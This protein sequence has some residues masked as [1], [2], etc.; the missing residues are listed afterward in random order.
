MKKILGPSMLALLWFA[1]MP[2][3]VGSVAIDDDTV[4]GDDDDT[5]ADDDDAAPTDLDGDGFT[6]ADGDCNDED[7]TIHPDA[8]EEA[9]DGIDQDCDGA[10]WAD[11]DGDGHDWDGVGGDDCD[12]E[13]PTTYTGADEQCDEIDHDCDGQI[14]S[15]ADNDGYDL[16]DDCDDTDADTYPGATEIPYDGVDQDCDGLD[17]TDVDGDGYDAS[18][19]NGLD[20]DDEDP[21]INPDATE[22]PN[23]LDD[24][25][26]GTVD[27]GTEYGDDDGDGF[28]EVDGD[29]DDVDAS[30]APGAPE[31]PY[32]G[33]DQDCDGADLTDVDG[34]GHAWDGA[35]GDD[36]DDNDA[37]V[38]PGAAEIDGDGIDS[39]CDGL[40]DLPVGTNCYGDSLVIT[41]PGYE[42]YTVDW[43]DPT[44]GPRGSNYYYDD[45]EFAA[46]AGTTVTIAMYDSEWWMDPYL[47][48]LDPNCT[49][50]AEDD[51]SG[52]D[53]DDALIEYEITV[54][55]I[56]TIIATTADSW[57]NGDYAIE[58]W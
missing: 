31:I 50:I 36:C 35:G 1:A 47:Y 30:I 43:N 17:L 19:V 48:L 29:C 25:C 40:D 2:G 44:D 42:T 34:D 8:E 13:D 4:A 45:I 41:V 27:E 39:N 54:S 21:A 28:A 55:G 51:D 57:Q 24:D 14:H 23:H 20:C 9:Y 58:T 11:V 49:V 6:E 7:A 3:C 26:D 12:D 10:D 18:E 38:H 16:C 46:F 33:V 56:Y 22:V 37:S 53:T 52:D 32:D 15:D 5:S